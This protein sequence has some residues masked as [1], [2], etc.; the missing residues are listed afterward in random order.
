MVTTEKDTKFIQRK[1]LTN[2]ESFPFASKRF[3]VIIAHRPHVSL[4]FSAGIARILGRRYIRKERSLAES[5]KKRV[6]LTGLAA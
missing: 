6:F 2:I 4:D 3:Y 5:L 1:D